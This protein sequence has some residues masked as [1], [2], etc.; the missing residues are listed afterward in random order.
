MTSRINTKMSKKATSC[1]ILELPGSGQ[2]KML[3]YCLTESSYSR[4]RRR[5]LGRRLTRLKRKHDRLWSSENETRSFR[6]R[7][8]S[9]DDLKSWK[10]KN[11]RNGT[12][13]LD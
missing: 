13:K 7:K 2:K 11:F 1:W 9:E 10:S 5:K 4:W 3:G 12:T 6:G 8:K